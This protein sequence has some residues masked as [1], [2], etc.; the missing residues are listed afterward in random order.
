MKNRIRTEEALA[1]TLPDFK[2]RGMESQVLHTFGE[3]DFLDLFVE[4]TVQGRHT[5]NGATH[6]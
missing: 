2:T 5:L 4:K 6:Y 3:D 1:E